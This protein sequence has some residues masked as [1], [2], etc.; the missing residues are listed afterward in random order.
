MDRAI[1][2]WTNNDI[3]YL[4]NNWHI[5]SNIVIGKELDRTSKAISM[6]G[7][8]LNLGKKGEIYKTGVNYKSNAA[9]EDYHMYLKMVAVAN[10][11]KE[12][13]KNFSL[14]GNNKLIINNNELGIGKN[15]KQ[16]LIRGN[17]IGNNGRI[18][19]LQLENYRES[20]TLSDFFTGE[21]VIG[22]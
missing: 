4:R 1:K 16:R 6:K 20:F 3:N 7:K 21:I 8:S 5:K 10:K 12:F 2:V 13:K 11:L 22:G 19:T 18:I 14:K 17:V 15:C 9:C